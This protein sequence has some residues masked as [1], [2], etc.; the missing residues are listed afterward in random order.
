MGNRSLLAGRHN[1]SL[2]H[3]GRLA[4]IGED[5]YDRQTCVCVC[6][7]QILYVS[8]QMLKL[9]NLVPGSLTGTKLLGFPKVCV[10]GISPVM[11]LALGCNDVSL[12]YNVSV[13]DY[14]T[15]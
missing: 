11:V 13:I 1:V 6:V 14:S 8:F 7:T 5:P 10:N 3:C 15:G 2:L 9:S 12:S 4:I